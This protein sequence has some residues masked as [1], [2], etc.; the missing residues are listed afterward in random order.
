MLASCLCV[1]E[2]RAAFA[3]WLIW[4][5]DKQD[6]AE[7]EL[8]VVDSSP[9]GSV[10]EGLPKVRVVRAPPGTNVPAKRNLALDAARGGFVAW[11][12]DDDWQHPRRL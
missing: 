9:G 10:Y 1:T 11:F 3:E 8:V 4:N 7:R 6:Y 12:D 5:F 2:S